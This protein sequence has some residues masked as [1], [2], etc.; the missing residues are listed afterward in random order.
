MQILPNT[1]VLCASARL[2][3]GLRAHYQAQCKE[4]GLS[5]WA[6]PNIQ[7]L[8]DWLS[9]TVENI[10]LCGDE[11]IEQAP[12]A[13]L[14]STQE[15]LLWEQSIKSSLEGNDAYA[16]FNTSGLV[17][18]A[19]EAN[20]YIIEWNISLDHSQ[21]TEE[22]KHFLL[23]RKQFQHL[24]KQN[25]ALEPVRY[26]AWQ[27]NQLEKAKITLTNPI[28]LA[29][30]DRINPH[31]I[32]LC[33]TLSA[34][35]ASV[36]TQ[37]NVAASPK[38]SAVN[39]N[40]QMDEC[41]AAVAWAKQRLIKQPNAQLAIVVPELEKL[42]ST[43]LHLLDD[44]FHPESVHPAM[45]ESTRLYEC[46]LG[47]ALT[48]WPIIKTALTLLQIAFQYKPFPQSTFS[49][50]LN[51]SFWSANSSEA[52]IRAK[53]DANMRSKLSLNIKTAAFLKW[54]KAKQT[55]QHPIAC[56]RLL[57]DLTALVDGANQS[58]KLQA[59]SLWANTFNA[60]L[61]ATQWQG[62]RALSSVE[63][64]T[65]KR[66]ERV[67]A[68]MA[69]LDHLLGQISAR[70][71]LHRLTQLCQTHI[72]QPETTNTPSILVMGMLETSAKPLDAVWVMGMNDHIWPPLARTNALIP[73]EDQRNAGT[74]NASSEVQAA[75]AQAV[76]LRLLATA[77]T[78]VFSYAEKDGD[79]QLRISPIIQSIP[80]ENNTFGLAN[81]LAEQLTDESTQH[82]QWLS[83]ATAP[84]V[85]EGE[86]VSGG[87]GLLQAQAICP[88]W[89]FY[90]YRLHARALDEPENGL[91]ARQKG[92]LIH[93]VL[94]DFWKNYSLLTYT[95]L[96]ADPSMALQ[97]LTKQVH[98]IATT[99]MERFNQARDGYYSDVFLAL[100]AERLSL[101]AIEWL[102]EVDAKRPAPFTVEECELEFKLNIEGIQIKLIIDRIDRLET[103][104]MVVIDY[105]TSSL[106][107]YKNWASEHITQPQLPLYA[108]FALQDNPIAAVC[109]GRLKLS[110]NGFVGIAVEEG[111]IQN[112][113]VYNVE[114]TRKTST[115]DTELFPTWST[116]MDFWRTQISAT[117]RALKEGN[118][119]VKFDNENDLI[120]C[121]VL[122]L[123]R[124]PERQLQFEHSQF[125]ENK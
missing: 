121:Q 14:S 27:L 67:L 84:A 47:V 44:T 90:Q 91:D 97:L 72:F 86:H 100:E 20:R 115:F 85:L 77:P 74:P 112:I 64:Q 78:C 125:L 99:V 50:L 32:S 24:C 2:A 113:E 118:A 116:V 38:I 63:Y 83:D 11:P 119:A 6:S 23:W 76:H 114:S 42:R 35:G 103:G 57:A 101:L 16:L 107:D 68:E 124:L 104:S 43:L 51:D 98:T 26:F 39:C 122:P 79:R 3:H 5:Q 62:E 45:A 58:P 95:T 48:Q 60:L 37:Q 123:L 33:A 110:D 117:A 102:I 54:V 92:T 12:R 49:S 8:S 66:F 46:S 29:G 65:V 82:W 21:L 28:L 25:G 4:Q 55:N 80:T 31:I 111:I 41:R 13:V 19:I 56:P 75:F 88:A 69:Q 89:A 59:P 17:N 61:A 94:A 106:L 52:D 34:K 1:I 30:F 70:E 53:L 109:F 71:A 10:L 18:A 73:A 36:S 22:T 87:A 7:I 96:N 93:E 105:K 15:A 120:Y 108:A 40:T 9:Q 81:T